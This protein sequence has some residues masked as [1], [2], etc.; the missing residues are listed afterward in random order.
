[1]A[2]EEDAE[3]PDGLRRRT[4][5]RVLLLDGQDRVLL[6]HGFD[7][8]EPGRTWWFT[9]GGGLKPGE[10]P[11]EAALRELAEE[12]GLTGVELGP[13]VAVDVA[14]FS[15]DGR[16]YEQRQVFYLARTASARGARPDSS[17]A[18][19][20]ERAQLAESRWWTVAELRATAEQVYPAALAELLAGLL[21][22]GPPVAPVAL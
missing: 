17:G 2:H 3:T 16:P 18:E 12:T 15:Y 9:P 20:E 1:M 13:E 21:E 7:P 22:D 8:A 6:F 5:A 19:D 14:R 10:P 4:A 11:R